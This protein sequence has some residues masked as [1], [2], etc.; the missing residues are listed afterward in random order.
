MVCL[1]A[2]IS[3]G[4]ATISHKLPVSFLGLHVALMYSSSFDELIEPI[5]DECGNISIPWSDKSK[6]TL[7]I[8]TSHISS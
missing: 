1:M 5:N 8:P 7:V 2:K 3:P 6:S 4:P